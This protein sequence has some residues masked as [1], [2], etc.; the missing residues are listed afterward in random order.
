MTLTGVKITFDDG[1]EYR[2]KEDIVVRHRATPLYKLDGQQNLVTIYNE[3]VSEGGDPNNQDTNYQGA[4]VGFGAGVHTI[5]IEI[6]SF[7]G[8]GENWGDADTSAGGDEPIT[9]MQTLLHDIVTKQADSSAPVTLEVG[10]FSASG[11]Y[12]PIKAAIGDVNLPKDFR[13]NPSTFRGTIEFFDAVDLQQAVSS[14]A[15]RS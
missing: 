11:K 13:E 1:T 12:D 14:A 6:H 3:F 8:S 10:E 4:F 5:E 9:L 15:R 2:A 7:K